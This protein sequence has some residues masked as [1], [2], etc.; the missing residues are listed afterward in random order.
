[1]PNHCYLFLYGNDVGKTNWNNI[2]SIF[3]YFLPKLK[4]MQNVPV[5]NSQSSNRKKK[6]VPIE[7]DELYKDLIDKSKVKFSE[8]IPPTPPNNKTN[9]ILHCDNCNGQNKNQYIR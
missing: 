5:I 2:M 1:M 4:E 7:E 6:K 3:E 9:L 8:T